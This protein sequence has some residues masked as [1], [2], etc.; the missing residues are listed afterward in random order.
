MRAMSRKQFQIL[1]AVQAGVDGDYVDMDQLLAALPYQ[2]TK[3]SMQF[4]IRA[5]IRRGLIGKLPLET[6]RGKQRI[7][8]RLTETGAAC[9]DSSGD[10]IEIGLD[11]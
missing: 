2:T 5:L 8:Y 11:D 3:Q 1:E 7:R 10:I 4:S 6:R 9:L